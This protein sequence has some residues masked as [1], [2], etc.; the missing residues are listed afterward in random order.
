[1]LIFTFILSLIGGFLGALIL[2][3]INSENNRQLE[4]IKQFV[5]FTIENQ[6]NTKNID[7]DIEEIINI[8]NNKSLVDLI[9]LDKNIKEE[10]ID[11]NLILA[12]KRLGGGIALSNDGWLAGIIDS[13]EDID[14][15]LLRVSFAKKIFKPITLFKDEATNLFFIRI[16]TKKLTPIQFVEYID[17]DKKNNLR[18]INTKGEVLKI[19]Y[20][21]LSNYYHYKNNGLLLDSDVYSRKVNIFPKVNNEYIG[22]P[23]YDNNARAVGIILDNGDVFSFA[24]PAD[25]FANKISQLFLTGKIINNNIGVEYV[26]LGDNN[27]YIDYSKLFLEKEIDAYKQGIYIAKIA[28]NSILNKK[29]KIGDVIIAL[30]NDFIGRK[31]EFNEMLL[32]YQAGTTVVFH[33]IRNKKKEEIEI[34]FE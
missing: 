14:F 20:V 12:N 26:N 6:R 18:T 21:S 5:N 19:N 16:D 9:L 24:V 33:I 23:V 27:L 3:G 28:K 34:T 31:K 7:L 15:N 32:E 10:N 11:N 25:Y 30:D 1:M 8:N 29:I 13:D 2:W 17:V 22:M 4:E